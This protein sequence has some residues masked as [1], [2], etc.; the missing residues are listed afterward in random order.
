[1]INGQT[2]L[3]LSPELI[4]IVTAAIVMV[5][6]AFLRSG[7]TL[8]V[9]ASTGMLA[10]GYALVQCQGWPWDVA[11]ATG[12]LDA[13][14]TTLLWLGFGIGLLLLLMASR[15]AARGQA[16]EVLGLIVLVTAGLMFVAAT[17]ELVLMLLGLELISVPTYALLFIGRQDRDSAEAAVKYF[18]LSLLASALFVL[19]LSLLYGSTGAM[20][21]GQLSEVLAASGGASRMVLLAVVLVFAGLGFKI[22]AVPFHFYA[23]DVYTGTTNLN[24]GLLAVVPKVAGIAV[25]IRLSYVFAMACPDFVWQLALIM[26]LLTMTYGNFCALRQT[27]IR[28]LLAYSSIAHAGYMLIGIVVGVASLEAGEP[29]FDGMAAT[30]LYLTVYAFAS[31]GTFAVLTELS[32][33]RQ[34]MNTLEQLSGIGAK[35]PWLAGALAVFLFSLAGIP[36]LA[37]FWGKFT[38]FG[39]ALSIARSEAAAPYNAWF[40]TLVVVGLLNAAVGAAYY[41]RVI[42]AVYFGERQGQQ[43]ETRV[44]GT[45]TLAALAC[46][47][48]VVGLGI[49]PRQFVGHMQRVGESLRPGLVEGPPPIP[50][51]AVSKDTDSDLVGSGRVIHAD[52]P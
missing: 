22:A 38:L 41:L 34:E 12:G 32:S 21:Y 25:M 11:G 9:I 19:G 17:D 50:S 49:L 10:A 2:A 23:P 51:V 40:M 4:L 1:M 18:F 8:S 20:K 48:L 24:A 7:T 47:V 6:G 14:G 29:V 52:L 36:P 3:S 33:E 31:L 37:G 27:H 44:G 26:S 13:L 39:G 5:G 43:I 46:A 28:R 30:L 42:S 45:A 35:R 15:P 16:G